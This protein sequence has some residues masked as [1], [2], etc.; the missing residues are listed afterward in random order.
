MKMKR[1]NLLKYVLLILLTVSSYD[2]AEAQ[3]IRVITTTPELADITKQIGKELV[4]VESLTK[5]VEFMHAVPVKPSFVP[6]LNRAN[7]LVEMGLD[8]AKVP[9]R[10]GGVAAAMEVL[11]GKD[12]AAPRSS[13]AAVG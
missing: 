4:D 9:H 11:T 10:A 1:R 2:W 5:G 13:R 3:Q 6:K 8:L 7:I 12:A